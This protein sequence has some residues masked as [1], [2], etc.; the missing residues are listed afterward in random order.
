MENLVILNEVAIPTNL[1]AASDKLIKAGKAKNIN[2]LIAK[3]LHRELAARK[4]EEMD[5]ELA[6]MTKDPEYQAEVLQ[7]DREFANPSWEA[8]QIGESEYE[9]G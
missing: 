5:N 7:M 3:A 6:E 4:R 8:W 1:F 9:K 2:E